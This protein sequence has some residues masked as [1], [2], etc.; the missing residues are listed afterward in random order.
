MVCGDTSFQIHHQRGLFYLDTV[1]T[2]KVNPATENDKTIDNSKPKHSGP[3][4]SECLEVWHRIMG[5][6]NKDD[7][8]NQEKVV[9]GMKITS[10][11][12]F[13]CESC[14]LGKQVNHFNRKP[15]E[16]AESPME[17]VH[18]DLCGPIS[19]VAREGFRYAIAFVDDYSGATFVYFLKQKSDAAKAML[20]FLADC[21]PYGKIKKLRDDSGGEFISKE[22]GDIL[23]TNQIKHESSAPYSPH[24]N[25]TVERG[26]RT[27]FEMARCLLIEA[28]LPRYLWTYAVMAAAY[29]RNRCYIQRHQQTPYFKLTGK[30]PNISNMHIFGTICYSHNH[31]TKKLDPR[32]T[33]GIFLG[34]DKVVQHTSFSIQ[35]PTKF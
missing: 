19:P 32:S 33:K 28:N 1:N 30:T 21:A 24:Q 10:K 34:Y 7:V 2:V 14:I 22:F 35:N 16:R 17:F 12:N 6:C 20:K 31:K 23:I 3:Q 11:N 13:N 29:T 15:D 26:W 27:L 4:K 25:G 8:L 9:N 18:T 5:H